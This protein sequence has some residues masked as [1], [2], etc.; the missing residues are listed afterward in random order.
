VKQL[1][2]FPG[3]RYV[4][5]VHVDRVIDTKRGVY[6]LGRSTDGGER[7]LFEGD[8]AYLACG[9]LQT[10]IVVLR[11]LHLYD[12]PVSVHDSQYFLL[13]MLRLKGTP[14][15]R[16]EALHTL[17]QL[18]L[19]IDDPTVSPHLV[20]LQGYTYSELFEVPLRAI[21]GPL[22]GTRATEPLVS[23][24]MLLQGFLHSAHS[25]R[26]W[27][28]LVKSPTGTEAVEVSGERNAATAQVLQALVRKLSKAR[29]SIGAIPLTPLLRLGAP[30][31]GDHAAG[32][33]PMRQHPAL[34]ETD[35]FGRP[36][37]W[38]HVHAVDASVFPSVFA[39]TITLTAM[40]NAH[41]IGDEL[42][43]YA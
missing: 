38:Q 35:E 10:T 37:G 32:S 43:R 17:A 34:L 42:D 8:R 33:L 15:V 14:G 4:P 21:V 2:D 19:E 36:A 12:V 13:P 6:I 16:Q 41:R 29:R 25:A 28:R 20:H 27:V 9:V 24:L 23:R 1:A 22:A 18:F 26:I 11:S 5:N 39:T 31:R 3:F 40:A 7:R 30:G